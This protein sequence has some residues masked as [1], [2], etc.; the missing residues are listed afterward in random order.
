M[1]GLAQVG[2]FAAAWLWA[3]VSG[4]AAEL[5]LIAN[6]SVSASVISP[7]DTRCV[8]LATRTSL[9]DGSH[10]TPV[11]QKSG[12]VHETFVRRYLGKSEAGLETYYRSLVF[13]GRALMPV[14]LPSDAEVIRYVARTKGAIGYI[15]SNAALTGVKRLEIQ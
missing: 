5:M 7:E 1:R 11:L 10:V 3:A 9:S 13:S 8:F 6:P 4:G 15:S 2:F 14:T 12:A